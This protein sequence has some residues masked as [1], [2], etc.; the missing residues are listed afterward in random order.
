MRAFYFGCLQ[1]PGHF[2]WSSSLSR[3][4]LPGTTFPMVDGV[5][6]PPA[7][8]K[9]GVAQVVYMTLHQ[10][11][12]PWT[13]VSFWDRSVDSRPGS[14]SAFLLEG[15][16]S[17]TAALE[18]SKLTF[19]SIWKRFTFQVTEWTPFPRKQELVSVTTMPPPRQR[20]RQYLEERIPVRLNGAVYDDITDGLQELWNPTE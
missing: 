5:Y 16:Y 18:R 17:F 13:L 14:N 8:D 11:R 3:A 10:Y 1:E 12:G 9:E 2:W 20:V 15:A 19:P 6:C 4:P 7:T